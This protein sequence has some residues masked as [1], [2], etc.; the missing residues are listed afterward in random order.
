MA[1]GE[2]RFCLKGLGDKS[3]RHDRKPASTPDRLREGH[4]ITRPRRDLLLRRG[5][6]RGGGQPVRAA[7]LEFLREDDRLLEIPTA[8]D[9]VGG[10][11]FYA[12]RFVRGKRGADGIEDLQREAHTIGQGAAIFVRPVIGERGRN[13]C[14]R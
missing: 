8:R 14:T 1:A 10:R 3:Q 6:A 9:P 13:S 5:T 7:F 11:N 12:H 2:D 4:L